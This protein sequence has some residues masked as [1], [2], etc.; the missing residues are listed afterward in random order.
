VTA[1][2]AVRA[3]NEGRNVRVHA[4]EVTAR[5]D[6]T[7][8]RQAVENLLENALRHGQ[9]TVEVTACQRDGLLRV[10]VTDQGRG[11]GDDVLPHAFEP[12]ARGRHGSGEGAPHGAGLGLAVVLA[13]AQAHGGTASARN[14]AGRGAAVRLDVPV[15]G[16]I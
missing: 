3:Q 9:G 16:R 6:P 1:P 2:F 12:F 13:V 15:S 11:F 7:R 14:L 10:D 8:L 4:E 5:L